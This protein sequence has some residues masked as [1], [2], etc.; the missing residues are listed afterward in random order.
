MYKKA[1]LQQHKTFYIGYRILEKFIGVTTI[2]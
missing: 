2:F 1:V